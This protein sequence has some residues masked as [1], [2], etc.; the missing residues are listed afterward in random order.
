MGS[1]SRCQCSYQPRLERNHQFSRDDFIFWADSHT[2]LKRDCDFGFFFR[3]SNAT[4]P[5]NIILDKMKSHKL[6]PGQQWDFVLG[7][8][9]CSDIPVP[10]QNPPTGGFGLIEN[11]QDSAHTNLYMVPNVIVNTAGRKRNMERGNK[12]AL[13]TMAPFY[14]K[15]KTVQY[16]STLLDQI[17]HICSSIHDEL[18][19]LRSQYVLHDTIP[20]AHSIPTNLVLSALVVEKQLLILYRDI[21]KTKKR[22]QLDVSQSEL[23][24]QLNSPTEAP[25]P[26][27]TFNL[28]SHQLNLTVESLA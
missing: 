9:N 6:F 13:I 23:R 22:I 10:D 7:G 28:N 19:L 1:A 18:F 14:P 5:H 4:R 16:P 12:N 26:P 11:I 15:K 2:K 20:D 24:K 3:L 25:L 17:R 8:I 27:P 21:E